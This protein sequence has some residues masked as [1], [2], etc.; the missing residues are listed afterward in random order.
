M[1]LL[2]PYEKQRAACHDSDPLVLLLDNEFVAQSAELTVKD[3]VVVRDKAP[4]EAVM[5]TVDCPG[6]VPPL[7][8]Y[9]VV[10]LL[11]PP[12]HPTKPPAM[13]KSATIQSTP[14]RMRTARRL[15]RKPKPKIGRPSN[16]TPPTRILSREAIFWPSSFALFWLIGDWRS[17][18]LNVGPVVVISITD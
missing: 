8:V 13:P 4:S 1:R 16:S 18:G 3:T 7:A 2:L 6:V 17:A 12:P 15:R 9:L 5:V 10:L 11:L 14:R